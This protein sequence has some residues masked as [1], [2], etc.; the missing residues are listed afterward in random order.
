M[1]PKIAI[2]SCEDALAFVCE[3]QWPFAEVDVDGN[4]VW[5]N[6]AYA[7]LLNAP[8]ELIIGTNF[9]QWTHPSDVDIDS[10][11]AQQVREGLISNYTL[12]KRYIQRGS[13]PQRQMIC[14]G[15]LSVTGKWSESK[16]AGYRVQ[17]QEYEP[18]QTQ[19]AEIKN[20]LKQVFMWLRTNWK[21]TLTIAIVVLSSMGLVSDEF[22][23][24]LRQI[25]ELKQSVDTQQDSLPS[26]PSQ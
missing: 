9:K 7:K 3:S 6:N 12:A 11:L 23:K 18:N 13:T 24:T 19:T 10:E 16:F 4:F 22:S 8:V 26:T 17:F 2:L 25:L 15:L 5:V 1:S 14:W 21:T 20:V